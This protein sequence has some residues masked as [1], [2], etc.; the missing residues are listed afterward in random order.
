MLVKLKF[1]AYTYY[2][3]PTTGYND[4]T[5]ECY[6]IKIFCLLNQHIRWNYKMTFVDGLKRLPQ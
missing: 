2:S 1:A 4:V 5:L 3:A 6:S